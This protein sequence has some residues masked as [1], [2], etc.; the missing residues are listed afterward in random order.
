MFAIV[1]E[2]EYKATL[3]DEGK[4]WNIVPSLAFRYCP[5]SSRQLLFRSVDQQA[6]AITGINVDGFVRMLEHKIATS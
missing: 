4:H 2:P 5:T 3:H 1:K 6:G